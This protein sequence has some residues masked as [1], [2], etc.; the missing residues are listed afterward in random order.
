[1]TAQHYTT[2]TTS[3]SLLTIRPWWVSLTSMM[4]H[5]TER[6]WNNYKVNNLSLNID[7]T[8]EMVVDFRRAQRVHEPL[9]IQDFP[10]EI[11]KNTKFPGV[12]LAENLTWSLNT[13][14]TVKKAQQCLHFLRR[15]KKA[16]L[17]PPILTTFYR[18]TV[19]SPLGSCITAWFENCTRLDHKNLQR[20]V[21]MAEKII[22]VTL[23]SISDVYTTHCIR[24][25][26][27][28]MKDPTHP[29][30]M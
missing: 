29:S 28:T 20:L 17:P 7:K 2:R 6:R 3:S 11:V 8:K 12:N 27:S 15:L 23:P 19:E 18:G 14:S 5:H 1:M 26:T 4:S 22:R 24:K 30:H 21:R 13:G 16:H 25:A 9:N 10:V